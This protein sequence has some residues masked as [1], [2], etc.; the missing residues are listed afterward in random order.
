MA[1]SKSASPSQGR[2][3][4]VTFGTRFNDQVEGDWTSIF[5]SASSFK[6]R[7]QRASLRAFLRPRCYYERETPFSMCVHPESELLHR[8]ILTSFRWRRLDKA[9]DITGIES[10]ESLGYS[11][12]NETRN[13]SINEPNVEVSWDSWM[14]CLS[15]YFSIFKRRYKRILPATNHIPP[16]KTE[17]N[18]PLMPFPIHN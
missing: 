1:S 16:Q 2:R 3:I 8:W 9:S 4:E 14:P 5:I 13:E 11:S 7:K 10:T 6:L 15:K 18:L 12:L 17:M